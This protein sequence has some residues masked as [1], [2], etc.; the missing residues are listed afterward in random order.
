MLRI[1]HTR[2]ALGRTSP[3]LSDLCREIEVARDL[4]WCIE[5]IYTPTLPAMNINSISLAPHAADNAAMG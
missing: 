4:L 3:N 5:M 2:P 1:N